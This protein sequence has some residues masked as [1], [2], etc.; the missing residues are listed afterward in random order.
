MQTVTINLKRALVSFALALPTG[1][2]V[3]GVAPT[4]GA[5]AAEQCSE[6]TLMW[7]GVAQFGAGVT[8]VDTGLNVTAAAG[9][10][11]E[12]VGA[13][14]DGVDA[15]GNAVALPVTV[16]GRPA[17]AGAT[18]AAGPVEVHSADEAV[19]VVN[20]ASVVLRRCVL[21]EALAARPEATSGPDDDVASERLPVTGTDAEWL[22][23]IT[24][25]AVA[26]I[27]TG[28]LIAFGARRP[29]RG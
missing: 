27:A 19:R 21:V 3:C 23:A 25:A 4:A 24:V 10:R 8:V 20:G 29:A 9:V 15:W 1:L 5:A 22:A 13:S 16:G 11:L 2:V 26:A 12:V 28:A 14:A 7:S 6:E 18:V 17:V